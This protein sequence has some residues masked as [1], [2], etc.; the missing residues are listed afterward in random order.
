MKGHTVL[1]CK[2]EGFRIFLYLMA[3]IYR[4]ALQ[5]EKD[6]VTA[7]VDFIGNTSSGLAFSFLS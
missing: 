3:N 4:A 6:I 7:I 2:I 1:L 5:S